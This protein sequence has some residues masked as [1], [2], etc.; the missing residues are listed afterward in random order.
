MILSC[1]KVEQEGGWS[2]PDGMREA[3]RG[4]RI[5]QLIDVKNLKHAAPPAGGGGFNRSA[6]SAGPG[7]FMQW[8]DDAMV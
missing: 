8:C 1:Y 6:H 7:L 5:R 4:L 2:R 3:S